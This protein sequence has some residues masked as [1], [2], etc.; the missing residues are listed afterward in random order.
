MGIS[1]FEPAPVLAIVPPTALPLQNGW[2]NYSI[3]GWQTAF[4]SRDEFGWV[5][6]GGLIKG[7]TVGSAVTVATLPDG[8]RP[9]SSRGFVVSMRNSAGGNVEIRMNV[10]PTGAI[11][12]DVPPAG[13]ANDFLFLDG[14]HFRAT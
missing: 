11:L 9:L 14:I 3:G 13:A 5:E 12:I 2:I 4:Y 8:F 6:V 1:I 10:Y 7:G